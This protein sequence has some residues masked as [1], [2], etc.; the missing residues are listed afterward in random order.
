[1]IGTALMWCHQ[2]L[3]GHQDLL[4]TAQVG[5]ALRQEGTALLYGRLA[6]PSA[7]VRAGDLL[8]GGKIVEGEHRSCQ[9]LMFL[10][11]PR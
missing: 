5:L 1:M 8:Y 2:G 4:L 6:G 11:R 9:V 3:I 7:H 10:A